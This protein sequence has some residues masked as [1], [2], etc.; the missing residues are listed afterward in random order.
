MKYTIKLVSSEKTGCPGN[1]IRTFYLQVPRYNKYS[2]EPRCAQVP[3]FYLCQE[4]VTFDEVEYEFFS[5]SI[6]K[7]LEK[8]DLDENGNVINKEDKT[9]FNKS[10]EYVKNN[11]VKFI[12][13]G[14]LVV[15]VITTIVV[16]KKRR[17]EIW[18]K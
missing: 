13:G 3:D 10:I 11:K 9:W 6:N 5:K 15:V 12:V 2:I 4:Y 8:F 16:I 7:E 18:E 1:E 14:A 17:D